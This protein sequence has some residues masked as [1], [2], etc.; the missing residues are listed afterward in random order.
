[1]RRSAAGSAIGF[2]ARAN[3]AGSRLE[4]RIVAGC[5]SQ[6]P[7]RKQDP[8]GEVFAAVPFRAQAPPVEQAAIAEQQ[9]LWQQLMRELEGTGPIEGAAKPRPLAR[10]KITAAK[11]RANRLI[12]SSVTHARCGRGAGRKGG[13]RGGGAY[14]IVAESAADAASCAPRSSIHIESVAPFS[15]TRSFS[16]LGRRWRSFQTRFRVIVWPSM[17]ILDFI[18][19]T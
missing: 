5:R 1:M 6:G 4:A 15:S 10:S 16:P 14:R 17:S 11:D 13:R 8:F 18:P 9:A 12:G 2:G 19:N 7:E 3:T